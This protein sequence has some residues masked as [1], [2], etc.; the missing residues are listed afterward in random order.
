[1]W[2]R[3]FIPAVMCPVRTVVGELWKVMEVFGNPVVRG[4]WVV[5]GA[6]IRLYEWENSCNNLT[7]WVFSWWP[8][9]AGG[10]RGVQGLLVVLVGTAWHQPV[11]MGHLFL[12]SNVRLQISKQWIYL[13]LH[14]TTVPCFSCLSC[15]LS[16]L[17]SCFIAFVDSS[18]LLS[19]KS[20]VA[21]L[22]SVFGRFSS[23]S[24]LSPSAISVLCL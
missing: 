1:M 2:C 7:C 4:K 21:T 15:L 3:K 8:E 24:V 10:R 17:L 5:A 20:W 22:D 14:H 19:S 23:L 12:R 11:F 9:G 18:S 6:V 16:C 13:C